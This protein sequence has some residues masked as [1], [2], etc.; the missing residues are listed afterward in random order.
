MLVRA[1]A[2]PDHVDPAHADMVAYAFQASLGSG[3]S[4]VDQRCL[5]SDFAKAVPERCEDGKL[6][7]ALNL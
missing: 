6:A 1:R 3:F 2:I 4:K 7:L 5:C